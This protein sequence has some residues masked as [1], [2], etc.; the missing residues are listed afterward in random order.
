MK[1]YG[2]GATRHQPSATAEGSQHIQSYSS[3][4]L[5]L[6]IQINGFRF[7]MRTT[8]NKKIFMVE[9]GSVCSLKLIISY[10]NESRNNGFGLLQSLMWKISPTI[11]CLWQACS[12]EKD[13]LCHI[14]Y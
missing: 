5:S 2:L 14:K 12:N 13:I 1:L 7:R 4:N 9:L 8:I 11:L 10:Y 3:C 6:S